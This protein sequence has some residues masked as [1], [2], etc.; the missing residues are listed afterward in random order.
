MGWI[1]GRREWEASGPGPGGSISLKKQLFWKYRVVKYLKVAWVTRRQH[2]RGNQIRRT[3]LWGILC[4]EGFG[5]MR[6]RVS[7]NGDWELKTTRHIQY[8]KRD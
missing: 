4:Q 1:V 8:A 2:E 7:N 6:I 5:V 3:E